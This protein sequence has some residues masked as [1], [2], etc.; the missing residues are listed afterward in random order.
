M[1][2]R[3]QMPF[4]FGRRYLWV[5][6]ISSAVFGLSHG[7]QAIVRGAIKNDVFRMNPTALYVIVPFEIIQSTMFFICSLLVMYFP[8]KAIVGLMLRIDNRS[9]VSY[10]FIGAIIGGIATP[11]C[12][13]AAFSIL[14]LEG[15]PTYWERCVEFC[16][17]MVISGLAGGYVM[18]RQVRRSGLFDSGLPHIFE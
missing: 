15:A 13:Y 17:P 16:L 6:A 1:A 18:W 3:A 9:A 11:L 14:P 12:A 4:P 8:A 5:I 2:A 10:A 7:I